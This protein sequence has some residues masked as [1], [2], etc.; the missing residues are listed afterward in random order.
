MSHSYNSNDPYLAK[1]R[2]FVLSFPESSEVEAWGHPTFRAG[3]KIFATFGEREGHTVITLPAGKDDQDIL[4]KE[5]GFYYP[6]YVGVHGW[7]GIEFDVVEWDMVMDIVEAG[8]R[9]VALKRMLEALDL[10]T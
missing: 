5:P 8:Y 6:K 4:L 3:K 1:L 7:I 10:G 2:A 9:R